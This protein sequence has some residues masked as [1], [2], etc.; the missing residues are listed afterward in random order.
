MLDSQK[1]Y[2]FW[3]DLAAYRMLVPQLGIEPCPL[4]LRAPLGHR[5][6]PTSNFNDGDDNYLHDVLYTTDS[7]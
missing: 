5:G 2:F 6:I 4:A 7:L 1:Q 3:P